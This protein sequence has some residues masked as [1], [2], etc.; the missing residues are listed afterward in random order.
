MRGTVVE[1]SQ[2][3]QR[4][5]DGI[6]TW[7]FDN[8][9]ELLPLMLQA[10]LL[11]FGCALSRYLWE[12]NRTIASVLLGVTSFGA[13][14]YLF[15][16]IAGTVFES[17]PYQTPGA[18][19][20]RHHFLPPLRS[21]SA[22]IFSIS[23]S[24]LLGFIKSSRF[25]QKFTTWW[26]ELATPWHRCENIIYNIVLTL[27]AILS[28]PTTLVLDVCRFGWAV[29]QLLVA[30]NRTV[31]HALMATFLSLRTPDLGQQA[32]TLDLRC[33][34][35]VLQTSLDKAFHL[36]A[37]KYLAAMSE[38]CCF[39]PSLAFTCLN[40]LISCIK[41]TDGTPVTV[42]GWRQLTAPSAGV[43]LRI[44]HHFTS[45]APTSNILTDL[46]RRY[47][48]VFT[49]DWVDFRQ[50]PDWHTLTAV[51][52]LVNPFCAPPRRW[53]CWGDNRPS[54]QEHIQLAWSFAGAALA[55]Y[56]QRTKV[57]RWTLRF[58]FDSLSLDPPPPPSVIADCL[59]IIAIDLGCNITNI[60]TSDQR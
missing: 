47:N 60:T 29:L 16:V 23:F 40:I 37:L 31:Y 21:A 13:L 10:A 9:M 38:L 7:Y 28:L 50:L 44:L 46:R 42:L 8:V 56:Q 2:S 5:L 34:L 59:K 39:D 55:V 27:V 54:D 43:S 24:E 52:L 11:L 41:I 19:I 32:I 25:Y 14:S 48:R 36:S 49:S 22:I 17:C 12:I 18:H 1:R 51:H 45:T 15:I 6:K 35:W 33:V 4:K 57:P 26:V 58:A 30:L 3:R 53:R 20:L